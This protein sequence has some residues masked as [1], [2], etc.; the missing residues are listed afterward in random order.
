MSSSTKTCLLDEEWIGMDWIGFVEGAVFR[1]FTFGIGIGVS[2]CFGC[3][4]LDDLC[5]GLSLGEK[6]LEFAGV[7]LIFEGVDLIFEGVGL[8]FAGVDLV[9]EG[10]GLVFEEVGLGVE[11]GVVGTF[12]WTGDSS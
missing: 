1:A 9:F 5:F 4:L 7:D 3:F 11:S 2:W 6:K 8:V 12:G 10:V